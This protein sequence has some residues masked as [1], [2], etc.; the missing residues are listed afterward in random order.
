MASK[1]LRFH[2]EVEQE[3]L[4]SL[5]WYRDRSSIAAVN[6]ENIFEQAINRIREAPHR[7]PTYF[8]DFQ[9]YTLRQFPFSIIYQDF[10]SEIVLIA[11][12]H[13]SRRPGYRRDRV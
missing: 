1:P 2:P 12:A 4:T 10:S 3:Y 6:F 13:A 11:V 8:R 9:K 5:S 7:W